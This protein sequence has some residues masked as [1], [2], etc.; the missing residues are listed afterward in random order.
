MDRTNQEYSS[1]DVEKQAHEIYEES[2]T[3]ST[4]EQRECLNKMEILYKKYSTD[5]VAN[6]Y[7]HLLYDFSYR[8]IDK[9]KKQDVIKKLENLFLMHETE[10]I[11]EYI[12]RMKYNLSFQE[13]INLPHLKRCANEIEQLYEKFPTKY[14]AEPLAKIWCDIFLS[15]AKDKLQYGEKI[16]DLCSQ[17]KEKDSNANTAYARVLFSPDIDIKDRDRLIKIFL[18]DTQNIDS[19]WTYFSSSFYPNY[20]ECFKKFKLDESYPV[21]TL[22]KR[23]NQ[24]LK[25]LEKEENY[26]KLK[27]KFLAILYCT[28]EIKNLLVVPKSN[29]L[30]G[31]YT[32]I[33]NI[34]YLLSN[35]E[36]IG[37]L[38]MND[39]CYMNDPL[40]GKVLLDFLS[41]NDFTREKASAKIYLT[42]FTK[43]IDELPM[44]SMYGDDGQGCCLV[45]NNKYFDYTDEGIS[46]RLILQSNI[47]DT[48]YYLYRVCY[49]SNKSKKFDI[50]ISKFKNDQSNLEE[51]IREWIKKLKVHV[52]DLLK[53]PHKNTRLVSEIMEF[54]LSQ[55]K[56]LFKDMSYSHEEELRLIKYSENPKL[57]DSSWIVPQ[58]YVELEKKLEYDQII[59]G[60]KV[61]QV[62]RIIPY[63]LHT[64]KV[65]NIKQSNI[66]YR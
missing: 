19:F 32:K 6:Q 60:P 20:N 28:L 26:I 42:C 11:A 54:I 31:H 63:L 2:I 3:K 29:E 53:I 34:K 62:N 17:V 21:K 66:K 7:A 51:Y 65:K 50:K 47:D 45:L 55:I 35:D 41:V 64:Q 33:Q 10:S 61:S 46:D 15:R 58:L 4:R 49:L 52:E 40:E 13:N 36:K 48:N 57:D 9:L 14:L 43:A 24:Y 39:A 30:I 56:Y 16:L 12:G 38:R 5:E 27:I 59:L 8:L 1:L 23:V 25:R 37:K 18:K 44:W 22:S